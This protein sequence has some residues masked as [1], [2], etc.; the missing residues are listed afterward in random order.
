[1]NLISDIQTI[2]ANF[3]SAKCEVFPSKERNHLYSCHYFSIAYWQKLVNLIICCHKNISK[4][5]KS[6]KLLSSYPYFF[7][8]PIYLK[9]LP[10]R[11]ASK[12]NKIS[13]MYYIIEKSENILGGVL[14]EW[15]TYFTPTLNS[16]SI[17]WQNK[18]QI[19]L[20]MNRNNS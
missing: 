16:I 19:H 7:N 2:C 17:S 9:H 11:S 14:I 5:R 4:K 20:G 12:L 8:E 1:M 18:F 3:I 10:R 13:H 6:T 15:Q